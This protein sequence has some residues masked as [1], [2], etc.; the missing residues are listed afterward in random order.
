M[1]NLPPSN[2]DEDSFFLLDPRIQRWIYAQGWT[3]LRSIQQRAIAPLLTGQSDVILAAATSAG[4]TEAAFLPLL[5]GLL[6][7]GRQD[8][9]ETGFIL[10]ISPLGAC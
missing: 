8:G 10:S 4:K 3:S 1:T 9:S 6:Q 5:T 2:F 7:S